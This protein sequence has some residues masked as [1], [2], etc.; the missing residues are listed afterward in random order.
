MPLAFLLS[1]FSPWLIPY[2]LIFGGLYLLY[3]G[4]AKVESFFYKSDKSEHN[5]MVL[6]STPETI[7][8][9][10]KTKIKDAVITD[11]ILSIEIIMLA[12]GTVLDKSI[13]IQIVTTTIV[14]IIAVFFVYGLV[15]VIVR[16]DNL[17]FWLINKEHIA[18]G[19]FFLALM[20]KLINFLSIVGTVA[21]ILVGGGIL[22]HNIAFIHH[23]FIDSIPA[24]LNEFIVGIV[25]GIIVLF[26]IKLFLRVKKTFKFL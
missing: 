7:L 12:L 5:Q 3:E 2:I 15:A 21:M 8:D 22:S 18:S 16:L 19:N 1:A 23:L 20:P 24:I 10:E 11:F 9:I 13:E 6:E 14:A 26:V 25:V 4:V 17:G